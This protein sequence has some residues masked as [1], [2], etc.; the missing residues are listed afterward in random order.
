MLFNKTKQ[1]LQISLFFDFN[2]LHNMFYMTH[3]QNI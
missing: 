3:K 2:V 1:D